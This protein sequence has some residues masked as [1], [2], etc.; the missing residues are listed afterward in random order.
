MTTTKY[1]IREI[2]NGYYTETSDGLIRTIGGR[3][4]RH[5]IHYD[6]FAEAN[7]VLRSLQIGGTFVIEQITIIE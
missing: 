5:A 3:H 4:A 7:A 6:S 1:V 2:D